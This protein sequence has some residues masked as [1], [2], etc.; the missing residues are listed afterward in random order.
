[1]PIMEIWENHMQSLTLTAVIS[2]QAAWLF[3]VILRF[4]QGMKDVAAE[5]E[6]LP[7]STLAHLSFPT[8]SMPFLS[9][10]YK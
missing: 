6:R 5:E 7:V 4:F 8:C 9:G 2:N 3:K 1:M 10:P